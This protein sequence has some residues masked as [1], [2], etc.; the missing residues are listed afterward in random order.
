MDKTHTSAAAAIGIK[1]GFIG[2]LLMKSADIICVLERHEFNIWILRGRARDEPPCH[3]M[4]QYFRQLVGFG[5][6]LAQPLTKWQGRWRNGT[7]K[8]FSKERTSSP[9]SQL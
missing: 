1:R 5:R 8:L 4:G 2:S 6:P 7:L 3:S 9:N